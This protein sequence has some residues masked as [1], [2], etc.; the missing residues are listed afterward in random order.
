MKSPQCR[1]RWHNH[2]TDPLCDCDH[3]LE[4]GLKSTSVE[5]ISTP[6]GTL[7]MSVADV[8]PL[9]E[10]MPPPYPGVVNRGKFRIAEEPG[11]TDLTAPW[12]LDWCVMCREPTWTHNHVVAAKNETLCE[13]CAWRMVDEFADMRVAAENRRRTMTYDPFS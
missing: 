5:S 9:F 8:P 6:E 7:A 2:C 13:D 4:G 11:G 12:V 1:T 10:S 3:H